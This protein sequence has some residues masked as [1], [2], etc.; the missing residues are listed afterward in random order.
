MKS[1]KCK[2][3]A[4]SALVYLGLIT[5]LLAT[6]I[7]CSSQSAPIAAPKPT[8]APTTSAAPSAAPST[9]ATA[10]PTT[11]TTTAPPAS[12]AV[13]SLTNPI[14]GP[15]GL[16][17]FRLA[18]TTPGGGYEAAAIALAAM[19]EKYATDKYRI[20]VTHTKG[21]DDAAMLMKQGYFDFS[22]LNT[23]AAIPLFNGEGAFK[24]L[25]S[26]SL[27]Y[28]FALAPAH[29]H[30][31]VRKDSGIKAFADLKGKK[32]ALGEVATAAAYAAVRM[33]EAAGMDMKTDFAKVLYLKKEDQ[34]SALKDGT[35]EVYIDQSYAGNARAIDLASSLDIRLIPVPADIVAKVVPLGYVPM[36]IKGGSYRG[37]SEDIATF[38]NAGGMFCWADA[39]EQAIYAIVKAFWE[40]KAEVDAISALNK[41]HTIQMQ[42]DTYGNMVVPMHPGALKYF[43][44]KGVIR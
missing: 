35:A 7:A 26:P 38:G 4:K 30:I 13:K 37:I 3:F 12:T 43:K 33:F 15:G 22:V 42:A 10:K 32:L 8:S 39:D 18:T 20:S 28:M 14:T 27:R 17:F 5:I 44:E 34:V 40:H 9:T 23:P 21:T 1:S 6:P 31:I 2:V 25:A 41:D 16:L 11:P 24:G 19:V 36:T 29:T